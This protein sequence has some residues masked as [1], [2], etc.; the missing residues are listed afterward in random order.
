LP[1]SSEA[2]EKSQETV[3]QHVA[4]CCFTLYIPHLLNSLLEH[5]FMLK[6]SVQF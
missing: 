1:C 2:A 5:K 3:L 6:N 4:K